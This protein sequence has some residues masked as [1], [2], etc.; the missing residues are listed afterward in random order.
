MVG[1][2]TDVGHQQLTAEQPYLIHWI[3]TRYVLIAEQLADTHVLL[4]VAA[5]VVSGCRAW[6]RVGR[7]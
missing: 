1:F 3:A 7:R 2:E 5:G 6:R 4:C